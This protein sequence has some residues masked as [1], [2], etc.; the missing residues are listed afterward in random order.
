MNQGQTSAQEIEG[1]YLWSPKLGQNPSFGT[2]IDNTNQTPEQ[3]LAQILWEL[4]GI[5]ADPNDTSQ[6]KNVV[7]IHG[8][9]GIGKTTVGRLLKAK[10]QGVLLDLDWIR[11]NHLDPDWANSSPA[12]E[13]M[14]NQILLQTIKEYLR[15]GFKN[16]IVNSA[17]IKKLLGFE[18]VLSVSNFMIIALTADEAALRRRV[19]DP[20]RDSGWKDAEGSVALNRSILAQP[21]FPNES[22]I[23]TTA[24]SPDETAHKVIAIM[25]WGADAQ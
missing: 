21:L 14:S 7:F 22:R 23:D 25:N 13:A 15:H 10:L 12:E 2:I 4:E 6:K 17:D 20:G 11:T 24:L 1:R 3:T 19:V 9:P 18:S 8:A 16:I 5:A